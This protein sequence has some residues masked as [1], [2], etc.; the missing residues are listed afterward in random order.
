MELGNSS[1]GK[2]PLIFINLKSNRHSRS[3]NYFNGLRRLG[4]NCEWIDV[5]GFA[6]LRNK[7]VEIRDVASRGGKF[8]ITSPSHVLVLFFVIL[9][10]RRPILDAGW[11]LYDGVISSRKEYGFLGSKLIKTFLID[12]LSI[13]LSEKVLVESKAQ[14]R[15]ISIRYCVRMKKVSV[16][17]TGFDEGR[18]A[19]K[20]TRR[21]GG[22]I[23]VLFRGGAQEEAGL[24]VLEDAAR[25]LE[26]EKRIKFHLITNKL[27]LT[28][29]FGPNVVLVDRYVSDIE[30]EKAFEE[31]VLVLGQLSNHKRL[32]RTIPH[33]FFEAAFMGKPYLSA[34]R[35]LMA[36]FARMGII[37]TFEAGNPEDLV[38]S[39]SRIL[40]QPKLAVDIGKSLNNWYLKNASQKVL[41]EKF[42]E[43]V[44]NK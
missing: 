38:E 26:P 5:D 40:D 6:D 16:L 39:I 36:D 13:H 23:V 31:A 42:L 34:N 44:C 29:S 11:P 15:S 20:S 17:L 14:Q 24:N 32:E 27:G 35:G 21:T 19:S 43:I 41:S 1:L 12:F 30:L 33:K 10:H 2:T 9:F 7:G 3:R 28:H 22:E 18:F 25:R 8:V 37:Y 4:V